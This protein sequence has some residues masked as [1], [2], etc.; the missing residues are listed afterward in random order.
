MRWIVLCLLLGNAVLGV[1]LW[2][3]GRFGALFEAPPPS[4][5]GPR[6]RDWVRAEGLLLVE[7]APEAVSARADGAAPTT[8]DPFEGA[9]RCV[10][11]GPFPA[12]EG[13]GALADGLAALGV[14]WRL[15]RG[16]RRAPASWL[17]RLG[18][19]PSV[20]AAERRVR[21]LAGLGVEAYVIAEGRHAPGVSLG[22]FPDEDAAAARIAEARDLGLEPETVSVADEQVLWWLVVAAEDLAGL[23][24]EALREPD[25]ALVATG[26][27]AS[28]ERIARE[29][30]MQ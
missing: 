26:F 17:V 1:W 11:V 13:A 30:I 18:D 21:E 15:G 22:L 4:P 28:C 29:L 24:L 23:S 3:S 27:E 7:E 9:A 14:R 10:R 6:P 8:R 25:R 5:P 12:P 16:E 2:Q 20:E 19:V